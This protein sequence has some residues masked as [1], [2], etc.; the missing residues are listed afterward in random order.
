MLISK[1]LYLFTTK[2]WETIKRKVVSIKQTMSTPE[3]FSKLIKDVQSVGNEMKQTDDSGQDLNEMTKVLNKLPDAGE[4]NRDVKKSKKETV[5]R[6]AYQKSLF[7]GRHFEKELKKLKEKYAE[8]E[9][10]YNVLLEEYNKVEKSL[11]L[12]DKE[13]QKELNQID[14]LQTQVNKLGE[15]LKTE[16]FESEKYAR[17][18]GDLS[19]ELL[20]KKK[21]KHHSRRRQ[22]QDFDVKKGYK[23]VGTSSSVELKGQLKLLKIEEE[24]NKIIKSALTRVQDHEREQKQKLN[25]SQENLN[26]SKGQLNQA[27]EKIENITQEKNELESKLAKLRS[28]LNSGKVEVSTGKEM[29]RKLNNKLNELER[30]FKVKEERIIRL[31]NMLNNTKSEPGEWDSGNSSYSTPRK[32]HGNFK[33][34]SL[35]GSNLSL[36]PPLN[37]FSILVFKLS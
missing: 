11:N 1:V 26:D 5:S 23:K 22:T 19:K 4:K 3:K 21:R 15:S 14:E 35:N 17:A 37:L 28:E 32:T 34:G 27:N 36:S 13:R 25:K 16:K 2:Y 20:E 29:T 12:S 30:K 7:V 33:D 18:L 9:K 10:E 6:E 24:K 8:L 31:K